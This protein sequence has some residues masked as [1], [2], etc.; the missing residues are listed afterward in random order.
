MLLRAVRRWYEW[1]RRSLAAA[2]DRLKRLL[3]WPEMRAPADDAGGRCGRRSHATCCGWAGGWSLL[4]AMHQP[5]LPLKLPK[6]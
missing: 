2:E 6:S 5:L 3:W 4:E 1:C